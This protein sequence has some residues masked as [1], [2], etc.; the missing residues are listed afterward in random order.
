M[1]KR[2][3][4]V[5]RCAELCRRREEED[6]RQRA[7]VIT[8]FDAGA[9]DATMHALADEIL[10][11][12]Q[13]LRLLATAIGWASTGMPFGLFPPGPFGRPRRTSSKGD[14]APPVA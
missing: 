11:Y 9:P 1:A 12:R 5:E 14:V 2:H 8:E 7:R 4:V 13:A 3:P 6:R 10:K